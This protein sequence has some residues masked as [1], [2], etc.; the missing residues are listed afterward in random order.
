MQQGSLMKINSAIFFFDNPIPRN[1]FP[2]FL[3]VDLQSFSPGVEPKQLLGVE[4]LVPKSVNSSPQA[5][6][7]KLHD[8]ST[9]PKAQT[10]S[11]CG[12]KAFLLRHASYSWLNQYR[13]LHQEASQYDHR[14]GKICTHLQSLIKNVL[15]GQLESMS[16]FFRSLRSP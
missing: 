3:P 16:I 5:S 12:W 15:T 10:P 13:P 7:Q 4:I 11:S 6:L 8:V 1:W 2:H 14:A 9:T